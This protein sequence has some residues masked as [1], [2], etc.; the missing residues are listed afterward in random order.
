MRSAERVRFLLP[1]RKLAQ[2]V[3]LVLLTR[4]KILQLSVRSVL[5]ANTQAAQRQSVRDAL[6]VL[7]TVMMIRLLRAYHAQSAQNGTVGWVTTRLN[8]WTIL[9]R[10]TSARLE[11]WTKTKMSGRS[12]HTAPSASTARRD[13]PHAYNALVSTK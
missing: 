12:A 11:G 7:L 3:K 5:S 1:L 4:T 8:R 2:V 13:L 10:V 6:T 9:P